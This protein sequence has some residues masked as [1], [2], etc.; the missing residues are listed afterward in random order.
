MYPNERSIYTLFLLD[1]Y[2]DVNGAT[3]ILGRRYCTF[4]I[5]FDGTV[6]FNIYILKG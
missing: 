5:F 2:V 3:S 6:H 1:N 4:D